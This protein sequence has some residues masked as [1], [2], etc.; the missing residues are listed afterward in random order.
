MREKVY[1]EIKYEKWK[2]NGEN[3]ERWNVERENVKSEE[4]K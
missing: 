4:R 1:W 2:C 3:Q